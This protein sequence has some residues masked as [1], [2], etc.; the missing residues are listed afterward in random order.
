MV[1]RDYTFKL[2]ASP[3]FLEGIARI[4]DV[5]GSL[6]SYNIS[7]GESIADCRALLSDWKEVGRDIVAAIGEYEAEEKV[8]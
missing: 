5:S 8:A 2:Y 6:N 4:V 1:L 3:S 7:P